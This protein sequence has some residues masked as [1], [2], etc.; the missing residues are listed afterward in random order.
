MQWLFWRVEDLF[1]RQ[2]IHMPSQLIW[3]LGWEARWGWGLGASVPLHVL[4]GF[5]TAWWLGC[6]IMGPKEARWKVM[7]FL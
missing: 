6:K 7:V 1:S 3:T 2:L 5:P 4:L